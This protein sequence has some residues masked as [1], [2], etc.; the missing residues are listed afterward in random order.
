MSSA[1][2]RRIRPYSYLDRSRDPWRAAA[3]WDSRWDHGQRGRQQQPE[4]RRADPNS[5]W[6]YRR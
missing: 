3:P 6:N 2:P 1:K 5:F 4:L